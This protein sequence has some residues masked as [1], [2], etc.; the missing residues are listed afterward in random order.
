MGINFS[1]KVGQILTC[2]FG[3]YPRDGQGDIVPDVIDAHMPPEMIKFRLVVVLNGKLNGNACTIV[4]ISTTK[5]SV[6][7]GSGFHVE[8]EKGVIE[9]ARYFPQKT[10]WVKCDMVQTVSNQRLNRPMDVAR[11][12]LT[13]VLPRESVSEI[14]KAVIRAINAS[15][16]LP[17]PYRDNVV[18]K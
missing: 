4:P 12:W 1:P 17:Q 8:L 11:G 16:L 7:L 2:N 5:D 13:Q 3:N 9:E 18:E 14:Q 15:S 6:K 10:S